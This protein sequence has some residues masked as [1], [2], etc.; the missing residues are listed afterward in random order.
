MNIVR[1]VGLDTT[2]VLRVLIGFAMFYT[3]WRICMY[4]RS[5][6]R[7]LDHRIPRVVMAVTILTISHGNKFFVPKAW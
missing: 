5:H 3:R 7:V 2:I 6:K 4:Y 1:Y